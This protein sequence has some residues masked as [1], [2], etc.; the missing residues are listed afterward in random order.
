MPGHLGD[1]ARAVGGMQRLS[2]LLR[3]PS[4]TIRGWAHGTPI[5]GAAQLLIEGL[6][7]LHSIPTKE[8]P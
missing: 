5:P 1:L 4:R 3:T 8:N 7:K 6:C 2:D